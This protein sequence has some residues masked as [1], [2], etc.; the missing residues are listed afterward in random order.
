MNKSRRVQIK[1]AKELL[2]MVT[3][4]LNDVMEN[5]EEAFNNLPDSLQESSRG[6]QI[7]ENVDILQEAIDQI[8]VA[9]DTLDN[10]E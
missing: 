4:L 10:I 8:E 3:D 2:D 9:K 1:R 5:E 6:E 7:E